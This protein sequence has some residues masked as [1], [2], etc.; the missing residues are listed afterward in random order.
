[1]HTIKP[2]DVDALV[3]SAKKTGAVLVAE[4][5]QRLGGLGSSV[6]QALAAHHPTPM[7]LWLSK[8]NLVK[9]E[10]QPIDDEIWIGCQSPLSAKAKSLIGR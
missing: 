3:A 1:M 7:A 10:P 4:E 9:V 8:I 5:H 6:A 2:L